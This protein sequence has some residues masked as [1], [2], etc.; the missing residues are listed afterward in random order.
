MRTGTFLAIAAVLGLSEDVPARFG[1]VPG[2]EARGPPRGV[3]RGA[4]PADAGQAPFVLQLPRCPAASPAPSPGESPAR[5]PQ[6]E[7]HDVDRP[8]VLTLERHR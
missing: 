4:C 2:V 6:P 5:P 8:A 1:F 3:G 7:P